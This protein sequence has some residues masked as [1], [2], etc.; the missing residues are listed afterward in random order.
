MGH[1]ITG[2]SPIN[3]EGLIDWQKFQECSQERN[4]FQIF[5]APAK[6]DVL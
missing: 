2:M 4:S 3:D 1:R 5:G 6:T